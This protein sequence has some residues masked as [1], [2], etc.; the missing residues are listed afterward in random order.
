MLLKN[1]I[2]NCPKDLGVINITGI[3]IDSRKVKKGNLFFALKGN[4]LNGGKFISEA[5]KKGANAIVCNSSFNFKKNSLP[6]IK[7]KKINSILSQSCAN[8][9]KKKP[10]NIIAVTGT[11]GKSSVADF[12]HQFLSLNKKRVATIGTLGIKKNNTIKKIELT[13]PDI[14]SLHKELENL[15]KDRIDDVIIEASSHGLK[16]GR[17]RGIKFSTGIFTNFSQDHLD[18][19]K[20]MKN[21]FNSKMILFSNLIKKNGYLITDNKLKEFTKLKKIAIKNK[22]KIISIN[23]DLEKK[24]NNLIGTFQTKNILMA[25]SAAKIS[26]L[27]NKQIKINFKKIKSVNGRLQLIKKLPNKAKIFIDYAHTPDALLAILKSLKK[28]YKSNITLVFGC[29]GDRDKKKRPIMAKIANKFCNKIYV[30]DDNPRNEN[31][32]KIRKA[33]IKYLDKRKYI[34]IGN[35]SKAIKSAILN[36]KEYEI[37]VIAGKGH[38]TYQDYGKKIINISDKK[39]IKKTKVKKYNFISEK[40]RYLNN[41]IILNKVIKKNNNYKFKGVTINSKEVKKN[42]LFI[43][44]KGE[45]KDGHDFVFNAIKKGASYCVVSKKFRKKNKKIIQIKNT[46]SF[47]N[48]FAILNRERSNAKIIGVTGSAGKTTVKT[49]LANVLNSFE[50]TYCSPKSYNNHYGVPISLSNIEKKHKFCVFEVGMSKPGEIN[51]LSAMVKPDIGIITNVAEAHIENFKNLKGIAD[52]KSEII[53]NIEKKGT[54]IINQDDKFYK[55]LKKKADD[56]ELKTITFGKSKKS[57]IRLIKIKKLKTGSILKIKAL[58]ES[59]V[60]K[61]KNTNIYSIL[62]VIAVLK[63]LNLN[64]QKI[65]KNIKFLEP[66]KGRGKEY[67]IKRFKTKFYL[68]DE[69]YNANPFS[70]KQSIQNLSNIKI[71]NSKKYLL[72]GDMLELGNKTDHYHKKLSKII[73]NADIDKLFIY[74]NNALNTYKHIKKIKRGNILQHKSDF[75]EIFSNIIKK[76]DYLMI[77]GS[78][79]TGLNQLTNNIIKG[80][81]NVI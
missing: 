26:G 64:L 9:F 29:G 12:Y 78:N 4:K 33:L 34:E 7:T 35:R 40:Y 58:D 72:L 50:P 77:K 32:K 27:K 43:A 60:L 75:D 19:H 81:V 14:V 44:I 63:E 8:F 59:V 52:A 76:N 36:S 17:L 18:Y 39:I 41:S 62:C 71:K 5:I 21:Y 53:N 22:L 49:I 20:T 6:I 3:S 48:K 56:K 73:N 15:K 54:L 69:S 57:D 47:L 80:S 13:S 23:K 42:N 25:A 55:T 11:N 24:K 70:V 46:K 61:I 38:E 51:T 2:K 10:K 30:T 1:L 66:I 45:K 67:N 37:V 28:F 65:S 31:P 16:Q 74:G 68:I 79:A